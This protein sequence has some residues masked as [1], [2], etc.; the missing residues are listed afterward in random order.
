M[1]DDLLTVKIARGF[2]HL[3]VD[4]DG[5]LT[6][7]DHVLMGQ[8]SARS[9]G[10]EEGSDAER[11][12]V[13]AY[14]GIWR[15]LHQPFAGGADAVTREEFITSTH[16]LADDPEAALATVGRLAEVFL[17]VAD[18][19]GDGTVDPD[20][21]YAF[22]TGH[23]PGLDRPTADNAFR[24]LDRDSNGTLSRTEFITAV[25][26]YWTSRDPEAP[27]NWWTGVHPLDAR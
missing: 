26:E 22:Q 5:R 21:F 20:E 18:A 25:L 10:H 16:S 9:L 2:D 3:D 27:G 8:R 17:S 6:E 13:D 23:F 4:G 24:H 15:D 1:N 14:V 12:I 19:D 7:Y 11:A